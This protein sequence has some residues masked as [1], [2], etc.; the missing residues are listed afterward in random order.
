MDVCPPGTHRP[1][2][3]I[4]REIRTVWKNVYFGAEPY[5]DAMRNIQS[6]G[7][8]V[9]HDSGESIVLYFLGNAKFWRGPDAVRIKAEL[10][11]ILGKGPQPSSK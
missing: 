8:S 3:S 5:L 11:W 10:K 1:I 9:G 7:D 6:S 2:S 4:A